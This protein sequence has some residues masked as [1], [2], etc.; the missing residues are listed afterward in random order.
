MKKGSIFDP[1]F[2]TRRPQRIGLGMS[3]AHS[4]MMRHDGK[5]D[6][7]SDVGKGTTVTISIPI[8]RETA[9]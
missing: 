2:T 6:I 1:F 8:M 3:L 9:K 4:I 7:E 5:I